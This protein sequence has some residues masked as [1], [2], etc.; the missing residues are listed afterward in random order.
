MT[1]QNQSRTDELLR[2]FNT[3]DLEL[4]SCYRQYASKFGISE[5]MLWVFIALLEHEEGLMQKQMA[6]MWGLP[7]QTINSCIQKMILQD[8]VYTTL[9]PY[10]KKNKLVL[11][12]DHGRQAA[13]K[14]ASPI[15]DLERTALST[16][17]AEQQEMVTTMMK[18]YLLTFTEGMDSLLGKERE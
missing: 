18:Q 8:L 15:R 16:F 6:D 17:T 11:L 12:T 9:A 10:S 14:I 1:I 3:F 7:I 4:S 2:F 5:T 13:S